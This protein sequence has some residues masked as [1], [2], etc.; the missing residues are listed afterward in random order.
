[1]ISLYVISRV[2][3]GDAIGGA[4][5]GMLRVRGGY[6]TSFQLA[7]QGFFPHDPQH[8]LGIDLPAIAS[9]PRDLPADLQ[10]QSRFEIGPLN[11]SIGGKWIP[12]RPVRL[13]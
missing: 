13:C 12:H 6:E 4:P 10:L 5:E 3:G 9:H 8:T 2:S 7:Q 11:Y 1:M